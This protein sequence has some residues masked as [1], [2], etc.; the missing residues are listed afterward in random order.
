MVLIDDGRAIEYT[1]FLFMPGLSSLRGQ[2]VLLPNSLCLEPKG[3]L[4]HPSFLLD[5]LTVLNHL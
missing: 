3:V 2:F 4:S 5:D 1:H